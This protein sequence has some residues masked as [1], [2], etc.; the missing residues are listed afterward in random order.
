MSVCAGCQQAL[1]DDRFSI[2][3]STYHPDCFACADCKKPIHKYVPPTFRGRPQ[4]EAA[5]AGP[6]FFRAEGG[7]RCEPCQ[8]LLAPRCGGCQQ[9]VQEKPVTVDGEV[10]HHDCLKCIACHKH[11]S[12]P[13]FQSA[14]G[15]HVTCEPCHDMQKRTCPACRQTITG[16]YLPVNGE[17]YHRDCFTCISCTRHIEG[18]YYE[19][20]GGFVC[21]KCEEGQVPQCSGC[22]K[23]VPGEHI[24]VE[25]DIF[26][27]ECLVCCKCSSRLQISH[28]VLR[29]EGGL[30]CQTCDGES[31]LKCCFCQLAIQSE[32]R[33]VDGQPC[34]QK[35]FIC[36]TC[37]HPIDGTYRSCGEN[38]Y[39]CHQC[40][41]EQ[42]PNCGLC[43]AP[44]LGQ[45]QLLQGQVF[46]NK[47]LSCATCG[48][49]L[50]DGVGE[51]RC[52]D[53]GGQRFCMSC[54]ET[55]NPQQVCA[56]CNS[57]ITGPS[58]TAQGVPYHQLCF[59]CAKCKKTISDSYISMEDGN[60]CS[61][62]QISK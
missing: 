30:V 43:G 39:T 22:R 25:Q 51:A 20:N 33:I 23:P 55:A 36:E 52:Y 27:P 6:F 61:S 60:F 44:V 10:F 45:Q 11:I 24:T 4:F 2:D 48:N 53:V 13:F 9:P 19:K 42:V 26:H 56:S 8:D 16:D 37:K 17:S 12:G 28:K 1:E 54:Y 18:K 7:V 31:A 47:C 29:S 41:Q 15:G 59:C 21:V 57:A 35:C 50:V 32:Y 3:G 46:H 62:C 38:Q 49:A 58:V 5:A 40:H 14:A 34:H